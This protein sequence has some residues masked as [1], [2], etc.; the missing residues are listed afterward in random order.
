MADKS[1]FE[2]EQSQH[3]RKVDHA[4]L[5]KTIILLDLVGINGCNQLGATHFVGY[6]SSHIQRALVG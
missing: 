5:N 4:V 3:G 1:R 2:L 6:L